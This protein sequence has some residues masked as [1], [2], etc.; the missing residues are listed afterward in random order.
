M[1]IMK[2]RQ[3]AILATSNDE[4]GQRIVSLVADLERKLREIDK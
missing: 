4:T 2:Y 1:K 3:A